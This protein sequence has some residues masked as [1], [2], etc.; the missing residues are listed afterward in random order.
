MVPRSARLP[1]ELI[2]PDG[3]D[4]ARLETWPRVVGRLEWVGG[5]LLWMPPCGEA[6]QVTVM[7]ISRVLGSWQQLHPEFSAGTNEADMRLGDDTRAAD[8][9]VWRRRPGPPRSGLR[10]EPPILAVE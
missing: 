5:R 10:R 7:D 8:V 6:Q 2:P 4:P 3:F 9:G 1:V